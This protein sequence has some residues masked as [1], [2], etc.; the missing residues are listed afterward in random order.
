M[1]EKKSRGW[2]GGGREMDEMRDDGGIKQREQANCSNTIKRKW[3]IC[4]LQAKGTENGHSAHSRQKGKGT[5][6]LLKQ[7]VCTVSQV[8]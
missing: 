6:L 4:S 8:H 7:A 5:E 2:R 1:R 3:A